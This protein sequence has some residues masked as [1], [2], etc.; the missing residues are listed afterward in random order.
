MTASSVHLKIRD[1]QKRKKPHEELHELIERNHTRMGQATSEARSLLKR[2]KQE[3]NVYAHKHP[4]L[5]H[6]IETAKPVYDVVRIPTGI[7][8]FDKLIE[9]G[10]PE[11]S[12]I[13]LT[14]PCGSGKSIFSMR[15]LI[16]GA[17][18]GE[19]GVYVSLKESIEESMNQMRFFGWPID[20][21]V[22]SGKVMIV[23]PELY[24]FEA[25]LT[26]IEDAIER[27]G[28]RRLVVDTIS[29][30]GMYFEAPFKI[31]K[32]LLDLGYLL[33]KLG[34][35]TIAISEVGEAH[36]ELSLYGVEEFVADGVIVLFVMKIKRG[37]SFLRSIAVRKLRSTNHSIKIHPIEIRRPGGV[38][39]Y[40]DD[41][42]FTDA[43]S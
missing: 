28:A 35:T 8:G 32:A 41:E 33:K 34:C 43:T 19:P 27:V 6:E 7:S 23:Q 16:E 37:S 5:V 38:I 13:L 4:R 21:L 31:R 11:R 12:L 24:N 42:I 30:I 9:G 36:R 29:I 22:E 18:N 1:E 26:A 2:F 14:G 39:V 40:P 10:I 17:M 15:F 25:L 3:Y 20:S